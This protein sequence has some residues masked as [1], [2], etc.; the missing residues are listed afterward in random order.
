MG[1]FMRT[2]LLISAAALA[3]AFAGNLYA[4]DVVTTG[5]LN[6]IG[7]WYGRAGGL[8]GS[9]RV[10]GFPTAGAKVGISYDAEVATRTNMQRRD[11][12]GS[13]LGVSYDAEVAKRTNMPR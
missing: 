4:A 6:N 3:A 1:A 8:A 2:K 10:T 12:N 11:D 13:Q 9:D 5:D 7:Q